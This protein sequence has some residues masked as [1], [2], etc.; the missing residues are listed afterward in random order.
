MVLKHRVDRGE[1]VIELRR[2]LKFKKRR[3]KYRDTKRRTERR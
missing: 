2:E 1:E 3:V